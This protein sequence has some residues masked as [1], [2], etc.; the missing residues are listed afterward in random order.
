[1]RFP[2]AI[3]RLLVLQGFVSSCLTLMS[4]N[5]GDKLEL[6]VTAI[7]LCAFTSAFLNT[8][9]SW[10]ISV[11]LAQLGFPEVWSVYNHKCSDVRAFIVTIQ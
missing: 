3:P 10:E 9:M 11:A 6:C 1:M 8:N 4:C 5:T 2:Y 7:K